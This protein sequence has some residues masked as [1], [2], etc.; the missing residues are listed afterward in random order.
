MRRLVAFLLLPHIC[1]AQNLLLDTVPA[2]PL[3]QSTTTSAVQLDPLTGNITVRSAAGNL[4]QCTATTPNP[5]I[6]TSF[7][8]SAGTVTPSSPFSLTWTSTNATSCTPSG[9]AGTGWT[10]TT[11]LAPNGTA[12]LTAPAQQGTINFTLVCT[13]G[14]VNSSPSQTNIQVATATCTPPA[15]VN[16]S[17]W[18]AFFNAQ[19]WPRANATNVDL[20]EQITALSFTASASVAQ[21]GIM[22]ATNPNGQPG[23]VRFSISTTPG[24]FTAALLGPNCVVDFFPLP[25]L[26][27]QIG[28]TPGAACQLTQ[29]TTYHFNMQGDAACGASCSRQFQSSTKVPDEQ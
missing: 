21:N 27:W 11:Q 19:V 20:S 23:N 8:A 24:C 3:T 25:A 28:G 15:S 6:I 5:P 26:S 9:G 17:S 1:L 22:Q 14:S 10:S 2:I 13:N 29:G 12:N 18:E 16:P 4:M 7:Q